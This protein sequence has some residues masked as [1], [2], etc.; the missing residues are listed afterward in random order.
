MRVS[1]SCCT[2]LFSAPSPCWLR[3]TSPS[4]P[5]WNHSSSPA[6][7][8]RI[9]RV[10]MRSH[11]PRREEVAERTA[12]GKAKAEIFRC[13]E[14]EVA[15]QVNELLVEPGGNAHRRRPREGMKPWFC[16]TE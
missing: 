14:R 3:P 15:R 12:E 8:H 13:R 5:I 6:A 11:Q 7:R 9:V 2:H 16:H 1:R 4:S 10:G